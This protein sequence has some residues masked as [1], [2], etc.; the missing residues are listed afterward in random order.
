M[1]VKKLN[2]FLV[3]FYPKIFLFQNPKIRDKLQQ[4]YL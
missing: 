3:R 4:N 1:A 2:I